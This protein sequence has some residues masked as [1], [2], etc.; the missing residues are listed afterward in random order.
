MGLLD[1]LAGQFL[2]SNNAEGSMG[3]LAGLLEQQGGV[4]GLLEKFQQGGLG[5]V[6]QSWVSSGEN[7]PISAEQ[8]ESVLGSELVASVAEKFG[9]DPQAAAGQIS[10]LL[11]QLIDGL[12]PNGEVEAGQQDLVGAAMGLLKGKLFS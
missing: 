7:L 2:G 9:V 10:T 8:I 4:S 5:E 3:A 11:P 1:T 6:A 12:T